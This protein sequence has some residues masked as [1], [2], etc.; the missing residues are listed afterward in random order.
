MQF[1]YK[2][3]EAGGKVKE[4]LVE[5]PDQKAAMARLREQ[6]LSVTEIKPSSGKKSQKGKVDSKDVVM[7]S[8]QLSTL[9]SAGVPIVQGL[10]ILE[11]QAESPAFKYV[12]GALRTDI[13]AGLSIADAM[14]KHPQAFTELY[15][16][17]IKAGEV[18]GI[19]DT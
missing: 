5:A 10:N 4:G 7:F 1:A 3:K 19:L 13:E 8:R 15:V 18:G 16:A 9:V 14:G 6:K 12:V 11:A 2:A 17:M